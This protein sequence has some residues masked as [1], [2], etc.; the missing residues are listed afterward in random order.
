MSFLGSVKQK[1]KDAA[2][3]GF[4]HAANG[5]IMTGDAI[6]R[7]LD[8]IEYAAAEIV[9]RV[10]VINRATVLKKW[11]AV[12]KRVRAY[13][14]DP[15]IIPPPPAVAAPVA[16]TVAAPTPISTLA[17][18]TGT[19]NLIPNLTSTANSRKTTGFP[20]GGKRTRRNK[21][22]VIKRQK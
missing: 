10:P 15:S 13:L 21:R 11:N 17:R 4:I 7:G 5:A 19:R 16:A 1:A 14:T 18:S 12:D 20:F 3:F 8:G 6:D 9:Q 22:R 2:L